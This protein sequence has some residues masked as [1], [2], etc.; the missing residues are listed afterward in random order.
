MWYSHDNKISY[1]FPVGR[2]VYYIDKNNNPRKGCVQE[3]SIS[4]TDRY[5]DDD[6]YEVDSVKTKYKVNGIWLKE[7]KLYDDVDYF[8][9]FII[10]NATD[11]KK[12]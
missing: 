1:N 5:K 3:V 6:G 12:N 10:P 11:I 4:I 7:S 9:K 2:V 8:K